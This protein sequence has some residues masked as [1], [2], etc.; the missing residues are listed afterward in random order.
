[1]TRKMKLK[2]SVDFVMTLLL[3][4]QMAYLLIGN[5][6][7]EWTGAAMLTLFILHNGLNLKWYGSL[8]KGRYS[9]V[10]I[11]QTVVNFLLLFCM[12]SLMVSGMMMSSVVFSFF[13]IEGSMGFAR[14]LHMTAAYWGFILMSLHLGLHWKMVTGM[15]GKLRKK[16][17][18]P[19][20]QTWILRIFAVFI[21][22]AGVCA[23]IKHN[24]MSYLFLKNQFVFF[25]ME[26]PLISFLAEYLAM[27]GLWVCAGY[28]ISQGLKQG[29]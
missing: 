29:I 7:H 15:A 5:T 2:L 27:M 23:F 4:L 1:M 8:L 18:A 11:L 6:A 21:S 16:K 19:K 12:V 20:G 24:L 13:P 3:L 28:Y 10:R 26:Q 22:G 14:I 17:E 25:D 9:A